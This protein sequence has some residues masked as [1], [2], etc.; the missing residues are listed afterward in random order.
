MLT[1]EKYVFY[2]KPLQGFQVVLDGKIQVEE[3]L[4]TCTVL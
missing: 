1:S 2:F 4:L 3:K